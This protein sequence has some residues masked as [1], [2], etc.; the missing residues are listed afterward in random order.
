MDTTTTTAPERWVL[1][2]AGVER[3]APKH[4]TLYSVEHEGATWAFATNGF[5]LVAEK[6]GVAAPEWEGPIDALQ[7]V[8]SP[9]GE[10][11]GEFAVAALLEWACEP[12]YPARNGCADCGGKGYLQHVCNCAHCEQDTEECDS[13][14]GKGV[15]LRPGSRPGTLFGGLFDRNLVAQG[16][17]EIEDEQV[18]ITIKPGA[19]RGA[20]KDPSTA[21]FDAPSRRV[22]VIGL[23]RLGEVA[24]LAPTFP[25]E[26]AI[27]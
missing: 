14:F 11:Q 6:S 17:A 16:L 21:Y 15:R 3:K 8:L 1:K 7:R 2:N 26:S 23:A 9:S 4:Y 19:D 24:R 10:Y 18:T 27:V 25:Q 22:I 12:E 5:V 13:C 20:T